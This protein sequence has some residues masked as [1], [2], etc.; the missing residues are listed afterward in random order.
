M[1]KNLILAVVLSSLVYIGWFSYM[2][3]RNAPQ[4][5]AA[6]AA[7][8]AKEAAQA[9]AGAK[10]AAAPTMPAAAMDELTEEARALL[11]EATEQ[12]V[13]AGVSPARLGGRPD[14]V[15][16]A[17]K[18]GKAV[19][20]FYGH[21]ATLA[22]VVYEGPVDHPNLVPQ[23][24]LG[25]F[26]TTLPGDFRLKSRTADSIE[27]VS[28][29]G[30]VV[31]TKKFR[32][33]PDGGLNDFSVEAHNASGR[34][35][36]LPGWELTLGPGLD[37]V[38]TEME[39][40]PKELKAQYT[41][42]QKDRKH[43]AIKEIETDEPCKDDWVWAGL[44]NRYFLAALVNPSFAGSR[45]VRRDE[46]VGE[47]KET[48]LLAVPLPPSEL[49]PGERK[50]WTA[51]F[52]FGPK[53]YKRLKLLGSGLDRAVDFGFFAP[54]AKLANATLVYFH[55][56]TGNYG[57]AIILL[58]VLLQIILTPLSYK[59]YKAMAVMKKIQPEMQS[60]QARYK[61]DPQRL[62]REI[63]DLYKRHGTNPLG[64]CLPML[65][66]IPVFFALFTA[67]KNSWDLHGAH[68]V[69]W[70]T[71]LSAKDPFYVLPLVM[72]AVMFLQQ[73]LSPQ[74]SDPAQAAMMK[75]MPVIF[76]FMFLT[77]PSGLVL[78]WLVNSVWG[79]AQSMY[80]QKKMA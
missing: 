32:F 53:D 11:K 22:S 17:I 21:A 69:F 29:A 4:R 18:A 5:A 78:Y 77:F 74:T 51:Q 2:E 40:N 70:I 43:P 33:S 37:T 6:A 80:L 60:I 61:D 79:F 16:P 46:T 24:G 34:P 57:A 28:S 10:T 44:N 20:T 30:G 12:A 63:M 39:E 23:K 8:K 64:G 66:Q 13:Q 14:E 65:L 9:P 19:F 67:L 68:F 55:D 41:F 48:P 42:R 52:Y 50:A 31:I 75:W 45:P 36:V 58:S 26:R 38:K 25:F 7:A 49:K 47:N 15:F 3:K 73:H 59:S 27:F 71:D 76:T 1:N 72:G 54:I 56:L 35:Q 62:N